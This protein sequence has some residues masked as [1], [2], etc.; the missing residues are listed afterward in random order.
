MLAIWKFRA[1]AAPP[2]GD[3]SFWVFKLRPDGA[4]MV[5]VQEVVQALHMAKKGI[6]TAARAAKAELIKI[7]DAEVRRQ[8]V[9][10][11]ALQGWKEDWK[12]YVIRLSDLIKMLPQ[13]PDHNRIIPLLHTA[14]RQDPPPVGPRRRVGVDP[15]SPGH[16]LRRTEDSIGEDALS[17]AARALQSLSYATATGGTPTGGS[18][19]TRTARM[20]QWPVE[21]EEEEEDTSAGRVVV[22]RLIRAKLGR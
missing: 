21:G 4:R 14:S 19:A 17:V 10:A 11:G 2:F 20:P 6:A 9:A 18:G 12:L 22:P 13:I 3:I 1:Q 5:I 16:S 15:D 8:L 7:T